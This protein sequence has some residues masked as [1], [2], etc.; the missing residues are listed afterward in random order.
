MATEAESETIGVIGLGRMGHGMLATLARAGRRVLG[1]DAAAGARQAAGKVAG[2]TPVDDLATVFSQARIVVLSLPKSE[3]VEA[4]LTGR[5][6]LLEAAVAPTLVIDTSTI[7]PAVARRLQAML[8]AKGHAFIDAPVSGGPA[9]AA[10]GTL[11]IMVGGMPDDIARA[12]PVLDILGQKIV[13]VGG[14]G[15]GQVAKLV[16]NVLVAAHLIV[17]G[18]AIRM[19]VAAGA[20]LDGLLAVVNGASGR[21]AVTEVNY[22]RWIASGAFD[23]GF[24]MGLMAKDVGLALDLAAG[25]GLPHAMLAHV[26][27]RWNELTKAY[28]ADADF[29]RAALG[30]PQ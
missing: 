25:T 4:V 22:P 5:G 2:A 19:G 23:S 18:E 14:P 30:D 10:A 13:T 3:T 9:G 29:N 26:R 20:P 1:Y 12:R 17:A 8:A 16:N 15:D 11:S 28:G 27:A 24:S 21:S 7:D 6:G